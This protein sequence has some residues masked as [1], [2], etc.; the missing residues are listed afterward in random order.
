LF[1]E[2]AKVNGPVKFGAPHFVDFG[3]NMQHSPDGMAYLC[4]HGSEQQDQADRKFNLSWITGDQVYL[5]R[6]KPSPETINDAKAYEYFAGGETWSR[7]LAAAKPIAEWNNHMGCVT[8]SWNAPLKRYF[9]CV[10]DGCN[11]TGTYNTYLL[12]STR[13][14]GPWK[15]LAHWNQFGK[16]AYF[17]NLPSKFISKDGKTMW[18]CYSANFINRNSPG[19]ENP[20]GSRYALHLQEIRL[21]TPRDPAPLPSPLLSEKNLARKATVSASSTYPGYASAGA[22]DGKLGGYPDDSKCEWA[23]NGERA[24]AWLNLEWPAE[25]AVDRVWLFDR[26]NNLDQ[27]TRGTLTFSDGSSVE[28]GQALPDDGLQGL[29]IQFPAKKVRWVRFT[30]T[31]V[32]EDNHNIGLSEIA[33]FGPEK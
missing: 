19:Y 18:L 30:V 6:V 22:V 2:P 4:G 33:L 26:P 5:C 10:T 8:M 27:V 9:M 24:G 21:H 7:D 11:T 20:P 1:P 32:K 25:Q 15:R 13:I 28:V 17:V 16:Q 23:T 31:G 12:E 29:D 3:K 14:T